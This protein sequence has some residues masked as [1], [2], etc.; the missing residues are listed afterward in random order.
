MS[1]N[2]FGRYLEQPSGEPRDVRLL[3][4]PV[5]VLADARERHDE[6]MREFALLAMHR[7][8]ADSAP[9][10]L[11]ALTEV[12]GVKYGAS[13]ARPDAVVDAALA[14]GED[15]VDLTYPATPDVVVAAD[16]LERL[17]AEADE[18]CQSEDLLTLARTEL[19]QRFASWYIDEFRR[20]L[21]GEEPLPWDGPVDP[22]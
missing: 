1:E 14:A 16:L 9:A 4:V 18:F 19:Q 17:M 3:R 11:V 8:R 20:Q 12:L 2:A 5:R 7:G 22:D 21:A 15:T 13:R 6:L 10:R